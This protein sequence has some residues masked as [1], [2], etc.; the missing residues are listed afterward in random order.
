MNILALGN[1]GRLHAIVH[2]LVNDQKRNV[3]DIPMPI[4]KVYVSPGNYGTHFLSQETNGCKVKNIPNLVEGKSF[5][6]LI[7]FCKAKK[8]ILVIPDSEVHFANGIVDILNK[9]KINCFGPTKAAAEIESSKSFAKDFMI[10]NDI[11]TATYQVFTDY[12][13]A[14]QYIDEIDYR[15][16]IKASGLCAGKGVYALTNKRDAQQALKD[17]MLNK[18][19]G[20]AG[21]EVVV[22]EYLEGPELSLLAFTDGN[23]ISLLPP[24]QDYKRLLD[25]NQGPNTGGL[26]CIAGSGLLREIDLRELAGN[27][28][29]KCIDGLHAEGK[30]FRGVIYAGL[31]LTKHGP[32]V[33]EFNCRFGD[34]ETQAQLPLL[35]TNLIEIMTACINGWLDRCPIEWEQSHTAVVNCASHGY[36]QAYET[37]YQIHGLHKLTDVTPYFA[38]AKVQ[39]NNN[40]MQVVTNGG[41][42]ISLMAKRDSMREAVN[43]VYHEVK[44][45]SF[46]GMHYRTDIGKRHVDCVNIAVLGST[47]G[48]DM[49][50][51]INRINTGELN[52]KI[53]MVLSNKKDAYILERARQHDI[54]YQFVPVTHDT[55]GTKL[56]REEYDQ[57]M[58]NIL[59]QIPDLDLILMIGCMRI[60]SPLFVNKYRNKIYNIHPSLLPK[61]AGGMDLNVHEAVLA[62]KETESG[63]TVHIVT[64]DLD[65][66]PILVQKSCTIDPDETPETLK[67]KVQHLEGLALEEAINMYRESRGNSTGHETYKAAGVDIDTH[68]KIIKKIK[69]MAKETAPNDVHIQATGQFGA[70]YDLSILKD[71]YE[72]PLLISGTDGVGTKL[73]LAIL[74]N[75]FDTLGIDLVAMSANDVLVHGGEP[76]YFLDYIAIDKINEPRDM[77]LMEGIVEGCLQSGCALV[78]GETAQMSGLYNR[79]HFDLAGFVVGAVDRSKLLPQ[80][81]SPGDIIIGLA[82]D[83]LHSNGFSLVRKI[84]NDSNIDYFSHSPISENRLIDDLLT[85]TRIYVKSVLPLMQN[86]LIKGAAHIT[87]GGIIDNVSRILN[88]VSAN[89]KVTSWLVPKIFTW[90]QKTGNMT[91]N[92]MFHIFNM[93]IGMVLIVSLENKDQVVSSLKESGET[94]YEIGKIA[95]ISTTRDTK[96]KKVVFSI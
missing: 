4:K 18:K 79:N 28:L 57:Q 3:F 23:V 56:T 60:V 50:Y 14:L 6:K 38:G 10:R 34:P 17:I 86:D 36:P 22:E 55:K 25:D 31:M 43:T 92:E 26:G 85:P 21:S 74:A 1:S 94:V 54:P 42:V 44:K 72:D 87:G 67:A 48:T 93:G 37:G 46:T 45:I 49:Q 84:I 58:I 7:S 40:Q 19:F 12:E 15:V 63:C 5:L 83:G 69:T 9:C 66:G 27:V 41:R 71:R 29:Q 52:A 96:E 81:I 16:V 77:A 76:L 62:A 80:N 2:K 30:T 20:E 68:G 8:I 78:G 61:F 75:K 95:P 24:A 51:L 53:C 89:I 90:L 33:L 59:D 82:S 88:Q 11:P 47:R 70:I 13:E 64:K 35:K 73:M 65:A 32:Y 91:T 39:Y